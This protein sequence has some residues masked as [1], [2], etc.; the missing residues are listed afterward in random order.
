MSVPA[1]AHRSPGRE[2]CLRLAI[3][4]IAVL[5]LCWT[6]LA[7]G[8]QSAIARA[9]SAEAIAQLRKEEAV[10][11]KSDTWYYKLDGEGPCI[12]HSVTTTQLPDETP[13]EHT[14]RHLQE[15]R[16]DMAGGFGPAVPPSECNQWDSRL[17]GDQRT[18][19]GR[20][21]T[22]SNAARE[23]ARGGTSA[24]DGTDGFSVSSKVRQSGAAM[25]GT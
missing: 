11:V 19:R 12:P 2:I 15:I 24:G 23:A 8:L 22:G 17:A 3:V 10:P 13:E 25:D 20:A 16:S 21:A 6:L 7:L 14:A 4:A 1:A 18:A 9:A 5:L